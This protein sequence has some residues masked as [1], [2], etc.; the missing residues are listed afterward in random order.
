MKFKNNNL[1]NIYIKKILEY[2]Y[3]YNNK[4]SILYNLII[5]NKFNQRK[6][7]FKIYQK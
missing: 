1:N 5:F 6:N 4:I 3:K 7:K 2:F